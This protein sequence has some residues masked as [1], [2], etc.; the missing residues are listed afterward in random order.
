MNK[1]IYIFTFIIIFSSVILFFIYSLVEYFST[2]QEVTIT[3]KNSQNIKLYEADELNHGDKNT[4]YIAKIVDSGKSMRLKS[5]NSYVLIFDG[6]SGYQGDTIA[7]KPRKNSNIKIN[8]YFT[9]KRLSEILQNNINDIQEAIKSKYINSGLYKINKGSLYHYGEWYAT[10]LTYTGDDT[11]N[12]DTL[13]IVLKKE[14]NNW[15]VKTDPPNITLSKYVNKNIPTDILDDVNN[16]Q[17][18]LMIDK[19]INPDRSH[20]GQNL[21][22]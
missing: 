2:T 20:P 22:F 15:R 19:F 4:D 5:N 7:F 14:K 1:K 17:K 8:P 9:K 18:P 16:N 10:T 11:D 3:Y 6:K 13:R 12:S 21:N